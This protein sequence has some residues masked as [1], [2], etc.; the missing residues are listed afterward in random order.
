MNVASPSLGAH[1]GLSPIHSA[2][3]EIPPPSGSASGHQ[4]S[5]E[6]VHGLTA[7]PFWDVTAE[8]ELFPWARGLEENANVIAKEFEE[9]LA[10]DQEM[11]ASDSAWQNQVMGSGWSA[12]RLQ[13]LGVWNI[14]NCNQFPKTYELLRS[15]N[16]PLAV[17]GVCFARQAPGSGVG[18]HSDGRNFILTS[19][20]GIK[21]PEGAC[22]NTL[23]CRCLVLLN[24]FDSVT[25]AVC[26]D[27]SS[28]W[29]IVD[30][31]HIL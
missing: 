14:E 8:P 15:L 19:H 26:V 7:K 23:T 31:L 28:P 24:A 10:R 18:P 6:H 22:V 11:F 20:L 12:I 1:R 3:G 21:V 16:I 17:R 27:S 25:P 5:E 2:R 13:R 9:K 4:P 30:S 29:I